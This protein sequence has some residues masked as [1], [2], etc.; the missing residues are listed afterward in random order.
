MISVTITFVN[1]VL[2]INEFNRSSAY[3]VLMK[4]VG[5]LLSERELIFYDHPDNS[6]LLSF[7]VNGR[8]SFEIM[9]IISF[10]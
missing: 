5:D 3:Q 9:K 10:T 8:L 4:E 1:I 2:K 7:L 6:S